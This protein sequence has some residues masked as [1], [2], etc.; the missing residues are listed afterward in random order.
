MHRYLQ[1][2]L[3]SSFCLVTANSFAAA[4]ISINQKDGLPVLG[5]DGVQLLS[6]DYEFWAKDYKWAGQKKVKS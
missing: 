2:L 5:H 6:A 3:A 1:I 4:G